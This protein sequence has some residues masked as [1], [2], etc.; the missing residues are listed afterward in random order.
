M[1]APAEAAERRALKAADAPREVSSAAKPTRKG[2]KPEK[3]AA[4]VEDWKT[5]ILAGAIQEAREQTATWH[6]SREGLKQE[7]QRL[8][9]QKREIAKQAKA[10]DRAKRRV[11]QKCA[12]IPTSEL[13]L[14]LEYR[15][16]LKAQCLARATAQESSTTGHQSK[17]T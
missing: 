6:A 1:S 7:W 11:R 10:A 4:C 13:M 17:N 12:N 16:E 8:A 3:D 9:A 5:G 2:A 15:S 14:E